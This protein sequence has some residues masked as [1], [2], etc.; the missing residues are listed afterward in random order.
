VKTNLKKPL[1]ALLIALALVPDAVA[2]QGG[3]G[4][5]NANG[6]DK[7]DNSNAGNGNNGNGNGGGNGGGNGNSANGRN[8]DV[9]SS[10]EIIVVPD[11]QRVV[12]NAVRAKAALPLQAITSLVAAETDGRILDVQLVSVKGIYLYDVTVLEKDGVL[13]KLYY[14][15]RSGI[16]I[17]AD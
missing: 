5:G 16:R 17:R 4:Q 1:L 3:N 2:A 15:A 13:H 10:D 9:I 12:Q 11:D 6:H 7:S 14:N 8:Q